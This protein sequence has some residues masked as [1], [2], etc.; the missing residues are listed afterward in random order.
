MMAI[1]AMQALQR[2]GLRVPA[3]CSIT[4]FDNIE[5]AA[6]VAPAL[7]TFDQPKY[8]LGQQAAGM[9]LRLLA[10]E[11]GPAVEPAIL[12]LRGKLCIRHS[13]GPPRQ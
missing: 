7:T 10:E 8:D 4:G 5:L 2:A 6:Y 12:V 1:G 9:M 13:T 11:P 3:D